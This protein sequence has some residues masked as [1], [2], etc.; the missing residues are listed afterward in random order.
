MEEWFLVRPVW[1]VGA[2]S[3]WCLTLCDSMNCCLPG[4]SIHGI[5]QARI[6]DRADSPVLDWL[7]LQVRLDGILN[8]LILV[9]VH[10]QG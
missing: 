5:F 2:V 4:S 7:L 3:K 1:S 6:L 9:H 8:A 10:I